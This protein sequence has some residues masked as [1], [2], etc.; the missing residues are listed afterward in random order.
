M[1]A[2]PE[3]RTA[4]PKRRD[5]GSAE[6]VNRPLGLVD[7]ARVKRPQQVVGLAGPIVVIKRR[8]VPIGRC[9]PRDEFLRRYYSVSRRRTSVHELP[10]CRFFPRLVT[11]KTP[12][13]SNSS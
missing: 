4:D 7:P 11:E 5:T 1:L 12:S 8:H 9:P 2:P 3:K 10:G 13:A 6:D